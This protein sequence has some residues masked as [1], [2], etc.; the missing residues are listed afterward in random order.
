MIQ[1][2]ATKITILP[3]F[4]VLLITGGIL[5]AITS[6]PQYTTT[7]T[8]LPTSTGGV[9][10]GRHYFEYSNRIKVF[11]II[12][13]SVPPV[14]TA[15][16]KEAET[17]FSYN[18][19]AASPGVNIVG[20]D[21]LQVFYSTTPG[22]YTLLTLSFL[23]PNLALQSATTTPTAFPAQSIYSLPSTNYLFLAPCPPNRRLIRIDTTSPSFAVLSSNTDTVKDGGQAAKF[24]EYSKATQNLVFGTPSNELVV[25]SSVTLGNLAVYSSSL[26]PM[27]FV[28]GV[29]NNLNEGSFYLIESAILSLVD[30][31][32]IGNA[33]PSATFNKPALV[34]NSKFYPNSIMNFGT[35]QYIGLVSSV[36]ASLQLVSKTLFTLSS[37]LSLSTTPSQ[38]SLSCCQPVD[39]NKFYFAYVAAANGNNFQ[40]YYLLF[41][42]CVDRDAS[43]YCLACMPNSYRNNENSGNICLEEPEFP[44]LYG[45]D[46][47]SS[48][49]L[50]KGCTTSYC[51]SC[52]QDYR[53]CTKCDT[54]T[55]NYLDPSTSTCTN[56]LN[57]LPGTGANLLTGK[58]DSCQPS[59]LL[60]SSDVTKCTSCDYSKGYFLDTAAQRCVLVGDI[61][62]G[63]GADLTDKTVKKCV[64]SSSV[65]VECKADIT[66]CYSCNGGNGYYLDSV[67]NQ[68]LTIDQIPIG[69]G[70][71]LVNFEIKTCALGSSCSDC[72]SN[73]L[74][75][76]TCNYQAFYY[77]DPTSGKCTYVDN[78]PNGYGAN[79]NTN[80]IT[81]CSLGSTCSNCRADYRTCNQCD[82]F[83]GYFLK[84]STNQC[85]SVSQIPTGYGASLTTYTV[86]PCSLGTQCTECKSNN[87]KCSLCNFNSGY[88][89]EP[90]S[91][92]CLTI[93]QISPGYGADLTIHDIK[94]CS[95][96]T[97][98]LKCNSNYL[99][100]SEC[101]YSG[102]YYLDT[103][104]SKCIQT[105]YIPTGFGANLQTKT[106]SPCAQGTK[107]T[108]CKQDYTLCSLCNYPTGFNLLVPQG[109]CFNADEVAAGVGINSV[110]HTFDPCVQGSSCVLCKYDYLKCGFC[111]SS[112]GYYLTPST[113][114]CT[115]VIEIPAGFGANSA[116]KEVV[117]C[118][119]SSQ[120]LLCQS[121]Y[122][123]CT[124]CAAS[125]GYYLQPSTG[126][127]LNVSEIPAGF[128]ANAGTSQVTQCQSTSCTSCQQDYS[129][130]LA[131]SASS[132][133]F[134]SQTD[135]KCIT[136]TEIALGS[137]ADILN[138]VVKPCNFMAGCTDCRSNYLLCDSCDVSSGYFLLTTTK[139]CIKISEI[140]S[141][142]GLNSALNT[143]QLC[144]QGS[145]C[146]EC[147]AD[148]T[149]CTLCN[150]AAGYYLEQ[151]LSVCQDASTFPP[152]RGPNL[153][154]TFVGT[155]TVPN[156]IRC[157]TTISTCTLCNTELGLY[158]L[159]TSNL[160]LP[161]PSFPQGTGLNPSTMA[162]IPCQSLHCLSCT[163]DYTQCTQCDISLLYCLL[164]PNATCVHGNNL[165]PRMGCNTASGLAAGCQDSRCRSCQPLYNVCKEC[166]LDMGYFLDRDRCRDVNTID[167][168]YGLDKAK[169]E[170]VK[171]FSDGCMDCRANYLL[172]IYCDTANGYILLSGQCIQKN[173][174]V[175]SLARKS[176]QLTPYKARI[177]FNEEV[178]IDLNSLTAT[179]V[180]EKGQKWSNSSDIGLASTSNS[181]E[182]SILVEEN[183]KNAKLVIDKSASSQD[184]S[185]TRLD[186]VKST[187]DPKRVFV[188]YPIEITKLNI[189][190]SKSTQA[191]AETLTATVSSAS[192]AKTGATVVLAT[193]N[194]TLAVLLDKMFCDMIYMSLLGAQN[195]S[196]PLMIFGMMQGSPTLPIE[197]PDWFSKMQD[198]ACLPTQEL[199]NNQVNCNYLSNY[200]P[201]SIQM[202]ILLV[203]NVLLSI[204]ALLMKR[205]LSRRSTLW[206]HNKTLVFIYST[207]QSLGLKFF[208]LKMDGNSIEFIIYSLVNL[209]FYNRSQDP[210]YITLGLC[211]SI[212]ILVLFLLYGIALYLCTK[213][214]IDAVVEMK[215]ITNNP[216]AK[217]MQDAFIL[218]RLRCSFVSF[219]FD[220]VRY[221]IWPYYLYQPL[222]IY[223]KNVIVCV[224]VVMMGETR[225]WQLIVLFVL[226][227]A[228]YIISLTARVKA[229]KIEQFSEVSML[230]L[231]AMY[232][233]LCM[234]TY[235]E[236]ASEDP[237][238]LV[239]I[240][241][242]LILLAILLV[243]MCIIIFTILHMVYEWISSK[244]CRRLQR[245]EEARVAEDLKKDQ[246]KSRKMKI[247]NSESNNQNNPLN[248]EKLSI[249]LRSI[250]NAKS[251]VGV[252]L[253]ENISESM[254]YQSEKHEMMSFGIH[255]SHKGSHSLGVPSALKK[256]KFSIGYHQNNDVFK[257]SE[258]NTPTPLTRNQR[259]LTLG[260]G[261]ENNTEELPLQEYARPSVPCEDNILITHGE[262]IKA[263]H[264]L[265]ED[266]DPA[267][268]AKLYADVD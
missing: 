22:T 63:F 238:T 248:R 201:D 53:T 37:T 58:V 41:D 179:L 137:G 251:K 176:F 36:D 129:V 230:F 198:P 252:D 145:A 142:Y 32:D 20:K 174:K 57:M 126:I 130:C 68:C 1:P 258:L 148:Y 245:E 163:E 127:C 54:A 87:L 61:P 123:I 66:K 249:S 35:Y 132:N 203:A 47:L 191:A 59:C 98:C 147:K 96:G 31:K 155:C 139:T 183:I 107:C 217:E 38:W 259:T 25:A 140:E 46:P 70:A 102:G 194:P 208:I 181:L 80:S 157:P 262:Q 246:I 200:G 240:T 213:S 152:S 79:L 197:L 265:M 124:S 83:S 100:C 205:C 228:G 133:T 150:N 268:E 119:Q 89:L 39:N 131:C 105:N 222:A 13:R 165:P 263:K 91:Q 169:G 40:S 94:P 21:P 82:H 65:C 10:D 111:D 210:D 161:K 214:M 253:V 224:V 42:K 26:Q 256:S 15:R 34:I 235:T 90:A 16:N 189:I 3:L 236:L 121:D 171:C 104:T 254:F 241:M 239:G 243:N 23:S 226:E 172:C 196:Y 218:S 60:C 188:Q 7:G 27:V 101:N 5:S 116:T 185:I 144:Q 206:T 266:M 149:K 118:K 55:G 193:S 77:L 67:A 227:M 233:C 120:C 225:L 234:L 247:L 195:Q 128:G 19:A 75:C 190:N 28:S 106:I 178:Q 166:D 84:L 244:T 260:S 136:I 202:L 242:A 108:E 99:L 97:D 162:I 159:A 158:L 237:N 52:T 122:S 43:G 257:S 180:D 177:Y 168:G 135:K 216:E 170:V 12:D 138:R 192:S 4:I 86:E 30:V 48:I 153:L 8:G 212:F 186:A 117:P 223:V 250:E 232:I 24:I 141:G 113:G 18:T 264:M 219:V 164:A 88:Y 110:T 187:S 44:P 73:Y 92:T 51:I 173:S 71:D 9:V 11:W 209:R 167:N 81:A 199:V 109:K 211:C 17:L 50:I 69:K 93:S 267:E 125:S 231:K 49:P 184:G 74:L 64:M 204:T 2:K 72:R 175:L 134:L 14:V 207:L 45:K 114:I 160:C 146:K 95:Q 103:A 220:G 221:P 143:I 156:C 255:S 261:N 151:T 154:T 76:V 215:H 6:N 182:V 85:L 112:S 33:A 56:I 229:S 115:K 78:I 29:F 62:T